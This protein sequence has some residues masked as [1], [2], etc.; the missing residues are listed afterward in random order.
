MQMLPT[1]NIRVSYSM[2]IIKQNSES[3]TAKV[4]C[5]IRLTA[6]DKKIKMK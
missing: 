6:F 3:G 2:R 5:D 1:R 4:T